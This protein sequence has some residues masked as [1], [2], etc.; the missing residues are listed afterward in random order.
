MTPQ[1]RHQRNPHEAE[2]F[3]HQTLEGQLRPWG[4]GRIPNQWSSRRGKRH[5][6]YVPK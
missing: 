6:R 1:L 5:V 4:R 2:V 3:Q